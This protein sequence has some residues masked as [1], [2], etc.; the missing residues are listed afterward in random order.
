VWILAKIKIKIFGKSKQKYELNVAEM[1]QPIPVGEKHKNNRPPEL[2][3]AQKTNIRRTLAECGP[4]N[5]MSMVTSTKIE[6]K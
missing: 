1:D 3:E 6:R 2:T 4:S 5:R